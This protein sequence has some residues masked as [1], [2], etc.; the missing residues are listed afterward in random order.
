MSRTGPTGACA[1]N[2]ICGDVIV[3]TGTAANNYTGTLSITTTPANPAPITLEINLTVNA[4]GTETITYLH[5]DGLGSPVAK[6]NASGVRISQTKYEAYGMTVAGS[7]QPTIGFTGHYNDKDTELTYMQ[8]RYYDPVAGR[9][10]SEDPVLTDANSGASFNRYVYA[11]NN[12]YKYIDPDGRDPTPEPQVIVIVGKNHHLILCWILSIR[13]CNHLEVIQLQKQL[14]S[15]FQR[16]LTLLL[17]HRLQMMKIIITK[18]MKNLYIVQTLNITQIQQALSQKMQ[19]S[20]M[21]EL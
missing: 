5:T 4:V 17:R 16:V 3:S 2:A 1:I 8:Q 20:C 19:G 6:T 21:I 11:N 12:P 7:D 9:F 13:L 14:L 15:Y 10:L 18:E